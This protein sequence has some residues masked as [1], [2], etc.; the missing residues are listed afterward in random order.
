MVNV[1]DLV[2]GPNDANAET[3]RDYLIKLLLGVWSETEGFDGKRPFGNSSWWL[4]L[5]DTLADH[6][7]VDVVVDR[8]GEREYD[9]DLCDSIIIDAI[10]S[11]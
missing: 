10:N 5:Y 4:E 8:W 11:L 9:N 2:M 7:I 6:G 3:I 1:L